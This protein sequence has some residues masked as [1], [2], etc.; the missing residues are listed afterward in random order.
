MEIDETQKLFVLEPHETKLL[1]MHPAWGVCEFEK[2][3]A[4]YAYIVRQ[5]TVDLNLP[6]H[7][8]RRLLEARRQL[9]ARDVA[10]VMLGQLEPFV[11]ERAEQF[12]EQAVQSLPEQTDT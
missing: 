10:Q 6:R 7:P 11:I 1:K 3:P 12:S 2:A 8:R 9:A 4:L 5:A